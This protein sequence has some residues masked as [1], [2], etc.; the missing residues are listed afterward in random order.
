MRTKAKIAGA[1]AACALALAVSASD[2]AL[3]YRANTMEA[4]GGHMKAI[5]AIVRGDVPH[6]DHLPMHAGALA[7]LAQVAPSLFAQG[8]EGGDTLPAVWE[9]PEDFQA[10]LEAFREA[11]ANLKAAASAGEGVGQAMRAVG[12]ACK[13]CHDKYRAE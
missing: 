12:Q 10:K 5:V 6:T 13:G 4:I 8:S 11:T 7:E 3:K 2:G 9:E 1:V